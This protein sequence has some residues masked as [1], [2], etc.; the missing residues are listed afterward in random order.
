M[1]ILILGANGFIGSHLSET[2]LARKDWHIYAMD[3]TKDNT[4]VTAIFAVN[5]GG[6]DE[7]VRAVQK[8]TKEGKNTP[9]IYLAEGNANRT[10]RGTGSRAKRVIY[11]NDGHIDDLIAF[12]ILYRHFGEHLEGIIINRGDC[13]QDVAVRSFQRLSHL[14]KANVPIAR[15]RIKPSNEFPEEWKVLSRE[16]DELI[17]SFT[18]GLSKTEILNPA[19]M[20]RRAVQKAVSDNELLIVTS[21]P[22]VSLAEYLK[23]ISV[24]TARISGIIIMGGAISVDGNVKLTSVSNGHAEWNFFADPVSAKAVISSGLPITLVPLDVTNVFPVTPSLVNSLKA[25]QSAY[26][27]LTGTLLDFASSRYPYYLWDPLTAI[28]TAE[29]SLAN[30]ADIKIDV[31]T[32]GR[33]QGR[34]VVSNDGYPCRVVTGVDKQGVLDFLVDSLK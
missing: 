14:F 7:L 4:G 2:I 31:I 23:S 18:P 25:A 6:R 16:V 22:L 12:T 17:A 30:Y 29:S 21:G 33:S 28:I 32:D 26:S 27:R 8:L 20:Y 13:L 34:T 24:S 10:S 5:Y 11:D 15:G 9:T 19:T 3:L 1:N